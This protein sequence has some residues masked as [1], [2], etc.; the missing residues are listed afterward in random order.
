MPQEGTMLCDN[1]DDSASR[2]GLASGDLGIPYRRHDG[3][4]GYVFGDVFSEQGASGTHIGSPILLYQDTFDSSGDTAIEFTG[5]QPDSKCAQLF[6][7]RHDADNGFGVTEVTRI[8]ND[9]IALTV[10]GR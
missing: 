4:W 7:Y 2:F 10:D 1:T 5:S 9:A 6:D 8:P 3:G